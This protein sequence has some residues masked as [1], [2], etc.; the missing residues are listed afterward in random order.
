MT[1]KK[2]SPNRNAKQQYSIGSLAVMLLLVLAYWWLTGSLPG[3]EETAGNAP[4]ANAPAIVTTVA[5]TDTAD[6]TDDEVA[7]TEEAAAEEAA[8]EE[9]DPTAD[10]EVEEE[11]AAT[12][13]DAEVAL[14]TEPTVEP[15]LPSVTPTPGVPTAT[16]SATPPSTAT[17]PPKPTATPTNPPRAGPKGMPVINYDELPREAI[18]TIILIVEGG[19]FPF[20]RDGITFQNR[21]RLLPNKPRGYYAEYTVITPGASTRG[22]RRII[23]GEEGEL[24]YTDDHYESFSWVI[25]PQ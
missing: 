13:V 10:S 19:P 21:E 22:A 18:E 14:T 24:Y 9:A 2:S 16:P 11:S 1:Q 20:D 25:L 3:S 23:A 12:A 15:V 7:A 17:T 4:V 5:V 6:T 8:T